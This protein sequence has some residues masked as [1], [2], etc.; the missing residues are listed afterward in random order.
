MS[1]CCKCM[2][3]LSVGDGRGLCHNK[4]KKKR[5][6]EEIFKVILYASYGHGRELDLDPQ[7]TRLACFKPEMS[8]IEVQLSRQVKIKQEDTI[9]EKYSPTKTSCSCHKVSENEETE[10]SPSKSEPTSPDKKPK[11]LTQR[12]MAMLKKRI[13]PLKEEKQ[14]H[15]IQQALTA[16]VLRAHAK[17]N[18]KGP[19]RIVTVPLRSGGYLHPEYHLDNQPYRSVN[20]FSE[21]E[22]INFHT[23]RRTYAWYPT[24]FTA[25]RW[26]AKYQ[27]QHR[28]LFRFPHQKF[29]IFTRSR[30]G[31]RNNGSMKP[32][33]SVN[34][35][36]VLRRLAD[37]LACRY[38]DCGN[39]S[40]AF[41][42]APKQH[43]CGRCMNNRRKKPVQQ[44]PCHRQPAA[45][46]NQKLDATPS[47]NQ[48]SNKYV[49]SLNRWDDEFKS[50]NP[51]PPLKF[52]NTY[53]WS[54]R[55]AFVS[56]NLREARLA[57]RYW[58]VPC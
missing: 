55:L 58:T 52:M 17:S 38:R 11:S 34:D 36:R 54:I 6:V 57:N 28:T 2:D 16:A 24:S 43:P 46:K 4:D 31:P 32:W 45:Q 48:K 51:S 40:S 7:T 39:S 18:R 30:S 53:H 9:V 29:S 13:S 3:P 12:I 15:E 1:K 49:E 35:L 41:M 14:D 22:P 20:N 33:I 56:L 5:Q 26:G 27:L 19:M 42:P 8:R 23:W 25:K 50:R 21:Q 37:R 47:A 44:Q 10:L